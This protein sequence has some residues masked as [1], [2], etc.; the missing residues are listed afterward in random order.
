MNKY[1]LLISNNLLENTYLYRYM[2]IER[3]H[4]KNLQEICFIV[5]W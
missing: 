4:V 5:A 3:K 1:F 2:K